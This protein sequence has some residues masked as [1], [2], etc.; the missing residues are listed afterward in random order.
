MTEQEKLNELHKNM[1]DV[2]LWRIGGESFGFDA[3][4]S[5]EFKKAKIKA[6][7]TYKKLLNSGVCSSQ[8]YIFLKSK[9]V[10]VKFLEVKS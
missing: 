9:G 1:L 2:F 10:D 7:L 6:F 8:I 4:C 3:V 5:R